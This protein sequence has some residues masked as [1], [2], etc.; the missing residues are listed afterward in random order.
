MLEV[1]VGICA[2]NEE[3]NI[4]KLLESIFKQ[5]CEKIHIKEI[6]VVSSACTDDT[7]K[8]VENY[9]KIDSRITLIRQKERKGKSSAIN[10][11]LKEISGDVCILESA[12]TIPLSDAYENLCKSFEIADVGM[13][14]AHPVPVNNSKNFMGFV[15]NLLWKLHHK[16]AL[17]APKCGE[18]VAYKNI[19]ESIPEDSAVD[20]ASIE[21]IIVSK[22]YKLAYAQDAIVKNK[23][24]ESIGDYVIQRRRIIC[25]HKWLNDNYTYKVSTSN[26][27]RTV[28]NV[29]KEFNL[30]IKNNIWIIATICLELYCRIMGYYDYYIKKKNPFIWEIADSTKKVTDEQG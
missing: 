21:A 13:V 23:G 5:K 10:L 30:N 1:S 20:E 3:N 18:L 19:V 4:G 12:D 28:R 9:A 2:Y 16:T 15:V 17:I 6:V 8:I 29:L 27:L 22:G 25:G 11:F 24:P 26:M 7:D 14:G